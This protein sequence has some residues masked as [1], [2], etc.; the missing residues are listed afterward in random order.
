MGISSDVL[1]FSNESTRRSF[2]AASGA[3]LQQHGDLTAD[4]RDNSRSS[5]EEVFRRSLYEPEEFWQ[6]Q[7]ERITWFKKWDKVLDNSKSPF[8]KW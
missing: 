8:T 6:E 1:S 4:V 5:Y 3:S 7:A 2:L